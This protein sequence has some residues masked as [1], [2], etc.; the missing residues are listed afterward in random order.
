MVVEKCIKINQIIYNN[1]MKGII[2]AGGSGTRLYPITKSVS[3]QLLPVY[4]KLVIHWQEL[5]R[6]WLS[7]WVKSCTW[8]TCENYAFHGV[9]VNYLIYFYT[10]FHH[11]SL[12]IYQSMVFSK[13][14]LNDSTGAPVESFKSGLEK[15]IDWYMDNEWWWKNV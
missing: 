1:T 3:K 6:Y 13:P 4:D 11:H 9:I 7:Y 5:F 14:L 15:T 10:F 8:T 2:L 12:S